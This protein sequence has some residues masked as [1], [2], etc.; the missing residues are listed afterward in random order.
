MDCCDTVVCN[1]FFEKFGSN[2]SCFEKI[3]LSEIVF[4]LAEEMNTFL[5]P[6]PLRK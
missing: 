6:V 1:A 5:I 2:E 4:L 3:H